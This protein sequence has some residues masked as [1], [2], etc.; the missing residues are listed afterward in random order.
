[1]VSAGCCSWKMTCTGES[2]GVASRGEGNVPRHVWGGVEV[3]HVYARGG[4]CTRGESAQEAITL[5]G[6][7]K[8]IEIEQDD[9]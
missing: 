9:V 8:R 6:T 5:F 7:E 1:M 4:R 3:G 2:V